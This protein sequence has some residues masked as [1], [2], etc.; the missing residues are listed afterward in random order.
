MKIDMSV[1]EAEEIKKKKKKEKF[2]Y[3]DNNHFPN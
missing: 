2:L 3:I 1:I